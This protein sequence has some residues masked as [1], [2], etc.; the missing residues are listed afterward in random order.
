MPGYSDTL[1]ETAHQHHSRPTKARTS[2]YCLCGR[3]D[4]HSLSFRTASDG[5]FRV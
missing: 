5:R 1:S 2:C 4:S 3:R